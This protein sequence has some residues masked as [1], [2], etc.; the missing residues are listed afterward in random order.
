MEVNS[1]AHGTTAFA[2]VHVLMNR[3]P[4]ETWDV[5]RIVGRPPYSSIELKSCGRDEFLPAPIV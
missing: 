1:L 3:I 4:G 2:R 5:L